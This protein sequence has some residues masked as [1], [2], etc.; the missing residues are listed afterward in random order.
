MDRIEYLAHVSVWRGCAFGWL[1]IATMMLGLSFDPVLCFRSGAILAGLMAA[2]LALSAVRAP[3]RNHKATEVWAMLH[4]GADLPDGF[5]GTVVNETLRRVFARSAR[6]TAW[7][8]AA[9]AVVS[10][11]T[12]WSRA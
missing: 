11:L 2:A 8:A 7:I 6:G 3:S 10:V 12:S 9:M 1:A 4:N 5:P